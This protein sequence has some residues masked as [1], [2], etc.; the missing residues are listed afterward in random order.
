MF[1]TAR[2]STQTTWC[3]VNQSA[4]QLVQAVHAAVG[5]FLREYGP[6]SAGPWRPV[7]SR[8]SFFLLSLRCALARRAAYFAVWRG[9]PIRSP[10]LVTNRVFQSPGRYRSS[11][12]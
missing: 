1:F 6:L 9:L 4:G 2:D 7:S 10:S 5:D 11:S 3:L 12:A 8:P